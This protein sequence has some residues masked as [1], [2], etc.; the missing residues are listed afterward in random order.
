MRFSR[1]FR[2][3]GLLT[4]LVSAFVLFGTST[5]SADSGEYS[6]QS[7]SYSCFG[8][9]GTFAEGTEVRLID[10]EYDVPEC[11]GVAPSG[12]IWHTWRGAGGWH[13]MPGNGRA[14]GIFTWYDWGYAGR[15]IVVY[16]WDKRWC[17]DYNRGSGWAGYWFDCTETVS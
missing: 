2:W 16:T 6:A 17:Q 15:T 9:T 8:Y 1:A 4:S 12:S 10:W 13:E 14:R 3:S 5:A 7:V 11:F